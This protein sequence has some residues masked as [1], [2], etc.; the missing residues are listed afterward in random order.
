MYIMES[1]IK[2]ECNKNSVLICP[3]LS[4][5]KWLGSDTGWG[6]QYFTSSL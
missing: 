2:C 3:A 6:R 1:R 5:F 4:F